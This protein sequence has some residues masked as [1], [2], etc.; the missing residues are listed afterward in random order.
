MKALVALALLA[1]CD[2]SLHRMQEQPRCA[3]DQ[4]DPALGGSC[5]RPHPAGTVVYGAARV[6]PRPPL[7]R[8]LIRRGRDRFDRFCAPCHGVLADGDSVVA[9][10][11]KLRPPPALVDSTR[12]ALRDDQILGTIEH[13]YGLM[14]AYGDA[15]APA[16]RAAVLAYVRVLQGQAEVASWP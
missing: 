10:D 8:A 13:G 6:E 7:T 15:L 1:G 14:P 2:W 4:L 9:R 5:D 3:Q 11:M 12:R 16:D